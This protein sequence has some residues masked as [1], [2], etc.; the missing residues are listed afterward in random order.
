MRHALD[1]YLTV[2]TYYVEKLA[3]ILLETQLNRKRIYFLKKRDFFFF[4]YII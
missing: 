1:F 2:P 4:L 3:Y